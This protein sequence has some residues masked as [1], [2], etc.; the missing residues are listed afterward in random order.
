[1]A[2]GFLR[3]FY[4]YRTRYLGFI[5]MFVLFYFI[6]SFPSSSIGDNSFVPVPAS[7][8]IPLCLSFTHYTNTQTNV[9]IPK[10]VISFTLT[11]LSHGPGGVY[12]FLLDQTAARSIMFAMSKINKEGLASTI[13]NWID[14]NAFS[15][16]LLVVSSFLY[17]VTERKCCVACVSIFFL[18]V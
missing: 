17:Y 2:F 5:G 11:L 18:L 4:V 12:F 1:M 13:P 3:S 10:K 14:W 16:F 8:S 6:L 9:H 15:L 7:L